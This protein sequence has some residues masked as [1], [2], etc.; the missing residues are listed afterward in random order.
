MKMV[1]E[2]LVHDNT[3]LD[4]KFLTDGITNHVTKV[5]ATCAQYSTKYM[6][7][8]K[9]MDHEIRRLYEQKVMDVVHPNELCGRCM[10]CHLWWAHLSSQCIHDSDHPSFTCAY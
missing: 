9:L 8:T 4:D 2:L 1:Q 10:H 6:P 7:D 3:Y 5:S